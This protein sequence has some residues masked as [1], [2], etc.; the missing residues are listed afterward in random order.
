MGFRNA[1]GEEV[2]FDVVELPEATPNELKP[3][4]ALIDP[5]PDVSI[6]INTINVT[7]RKHNDHRYVDV[8]YGAPSGATVDYDSILDSQNEFTMFV[9]GVEM[10][11]DGTPVAIVTTV[12]ASG[13]VETSEL[14]PNSDETLAEAIER[15]G[16]NRFRYVI[17]DSSFDD[18]SLKYHRGEVVIT[19][20]EGS[21]KT[22]DVTLEDGTVVTGNGN[23]V[24]TQ[25]FIIEGAT[26]ILSDP[27]S[28][29][30]ID[31]NVLNNRNYIDVDF[32]APTDPAG[33]TVD[34]SSITDLDPEFELTGQGLGTVS[35]DNSKAP[36]LLSDDGVTFTFRY[37]L[38]GN[39]ADTGDVTLTYLADSWAF[40]IMGLTGTETVDIG[41]GEPERYI[42]VAFPDP[43]DGY[44]I[45][46][47]SIV[48]PSDDEISI[49]A[50]MIPGSSDTADWDVSLSDE[51][52]TRIADGVY[53]Y[54]LDI[55]TDTSGMGLSSIVLQIKFE[56]DSWNIDDGSGEVPVGTIPADDNLPENN[57]TLVHQLSLGETLPSTI[58]IAMPDGPEDFVINP[59]SVTDT[60]SEF[61]DA[62]ADSSNG[63]QI[64]N[65]GNWIITLDSS[66]SPVQIGESN[67]FDFPVIIELP[68]A[69]D[70]DS[71]VTLTF[72][73]VEGT[74][75]YTGPTND[76][77]QP[78]DTDNRGNLSDT[79]NRNYIDI[80]YIPSVGN[81]IVI[82]A[83]TIDEPG[84]PDADEPEFTLSGF[85]AT[86]YRAMFPLTLSRTPSVTA[87]L[88]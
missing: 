14:T 83:D 42:T 43:G 56:D 34:V 31:I 84:A 21:F 16:T 15:T 10:T 80:T 73:F 59:D 46:H 6:D 63:V 3:T 19:F 40:N 11:I 81:G 30:S 27:G 55:T 12:S 86:L 28:D 32:V 82:D 36:V 41:L 78:G 52:P 72:T 70:P 67:L 74:W 5:V 13:Q 18:A 54:K 7:E 61:E 2:A 44:E 71:S 39:F 79:N 85:G 57:S 38:T 26:A 9:D 8:V 1:S 20:E 69:E 62:D 24:I 76:G 29:A 58:Q 68:E 45:V 50:V 23:D 64:A 66:R 75:N 88:T 49:F 51:E 60:T 53:R 33:L 37:W 25:G 22:A 48:D 35:I 17:D 65:D 87:S 77:T 4:A 47:G